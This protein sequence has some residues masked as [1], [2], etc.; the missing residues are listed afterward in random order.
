[1]RA[2]DRQPGSGHERPGTAAP[3]ARTT[4]G[5]AA[6]EAVRLAASGQASRLAPQAAAAL[7]RSAGNAAFSAA[8]SGPEEH[9][10]GPGCGHGA[11]RDVQR[12]TV[13]D[14]L[15][16]PGRPLDEGTRTD[17]EARL[18]ADFSDVRV[19]TGSAAHES[20]ESVQAHAYTSG[21]HIVFQRGRYDTGSA[22][23]R[24]MLAHELTHVIQQRSG[25]V[26]GTERGDGTKVSD[27]SD[28]FERAA[29]DAATKALSGPGVDVQR[30]TDPQQ[31]LDNYVGAATE[32]DF[33]K[34][35]QSP[36]L[37]GDDRELPEKF[38]QLEEQTPNYDNDAETGSRFSNLFGK[39]GDNSVA[40]MMENYRYKEG[41]GDWFASEG[42]MNQWTSANKL[43]GMDSVNGKKATQELAAQK[44]LPGDLPDTL[45]D[46]I[47]RQ[48]IS[49]EAAKQALGTILGDQ[50][51]ITFQQGDPTYQAVMGTV[52]GKST[53]NI[54][55]TY[56]Q[57]KKLPE[58]DQYA[59]NGGR[60][61]RSG[62]N[63]Q[64]RFDIARPGSAAG[65]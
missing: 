48:N 64:L 57:I 49:G 1:M 62:H 60:L 46:Q 12:S 53:K 29:E 63:L 7:Q 6:R 25:P 65:T 18:G 59:I 31:R 5:Q 41:S 2:Q 27:P 44:N 36:A 17:M 3:A 22:A 39:Q 50:D 11:P 14:V 40:V 51:S 24:H 32:R 54:V 33:M 16:T 38:Y 26:S 9:R 55:A 10:H 61:Y 23:G 42:F 21:S 13:H 30:V 34:V 20:A 4:A 47:Y 56:N 37:S 52:N 15:R 43:F 8:V 45:P 28:R 35:R 19:H 58:N